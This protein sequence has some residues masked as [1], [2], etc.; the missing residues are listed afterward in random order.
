MSQSLVPQELLAPLEASRRVMEFHGRKIDLTRYSARSIWL[1]LTNRNS[2]PGTSTR[3]I[4]FH[5][6]RRV[7]QVRF[8]SLLVASAPHAAEARLLQLQFLHQ[9]FG[10]LG[11]EL[12]R[13][14]RLQPYVDGDTGY[15]PL[16]DGRFALVD[17]AE[18]GRCANRNWFVKE[19]CVQS[20]ILGRHVALY[21]LVLGNDLPK[22]I[23]PVYHD[24]DR[25]NC[26]RGNLGV[27]NYAEANWSGRKIAKKTTSD[28]KGVSWAKGQALWRA[29]IRK[30]GKM[31]PLGDFRSEWAAARAYDEAARELFGEFAALNFPRPG[32]L[33]A[34][35]PKDANGEGRRFDRS[36]AA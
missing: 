26:R 32:E 5:P 21:R 24:G 30:D 3:G 34:H 28:Y 36:L 10:K 23:K 13:I 16:P 2:K 9:A 25:L 7:W 33:A 14:S 29:K 4:T 31:F 12:D 27:A 11:L 1:S 18:F 20:K 15:L 35:R 8:G 17:A 6:E 22:L 19:G